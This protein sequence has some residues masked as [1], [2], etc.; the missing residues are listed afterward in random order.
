EA[1]RA[2]VVASGVWFAALRLARENAERLGAQVRFVQ[3][4]LLAGLGRPVDVLVANVPYV[5]RAELD[6]AQP[7]VRE[8]EPRLALLGGDEGTEVIAR[9]LEQLPAALAPGGTALLEI[10]WRQGRVVAALAGRALP[11]ADVGVLRDAA[12]L[13]R[14][15]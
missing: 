11:T 2:R 12:G 9:L 5:S 13:D 15:L 3:A 6:A 10:G 7:E 4:D 8:H 1:A 14:V